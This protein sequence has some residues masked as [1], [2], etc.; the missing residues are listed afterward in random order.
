LAGATVFSGGE[1]LSIFRIRFGILF[2]A[3]VTVMPHADITGL[4]QDQNGKPIQ[5]ALV[6]YI[7]AVD[8]GL[9]ASAYTDVEGRYRIKLPL[10][11]GTGILKKYLYTTTKTGYS[12]GSWESQSLW[13]NLSGRVT[14]PS[15][16]AVFSQTEAQQ[17]PSLTKY[18]SEASHQTFFSLASSFHALVYGKGI[19]PLASRDLALVD[20]DKKDYQVQSIDLWDS[21]RTIL[22]NN[23]SN[24]RFQ[25]EK[26]KTGR[27]AFLGGSITYNSG[28][29]DSVMTYLKKRFPQ[30]TFDFINAGIPSVGSNMHAFRLQQDVFHRGKVDLLFMESL[31]NDITNEVSLSERARAT[32]GIVLQ[33]LKHNPNIDI[34]MMHFVDPAV[35]ADVQAGKPIHQ[36]AEYENVAWPYAVTSIHLAQLVAENY[37]WETFGANVHPGPLGQKIYANA[38]AR[39]FNV[40][41]KDPIPG[42][43]LPILHFLPAKKVDSLCYQFGHFVALDSA[44]LT[45]GWKPVALWKPLAG[46]IRPG[47]T[48]VP[49]LEA[50]AP[51]AKLTFTFTGTAI[52]IV[53]PAGPD[54][55]IL[56]YAIDGKPLGSMQ[57]FTAWSSGLNIP[58]TLN[59]AADLPMKQHTLTLTTSSTKHA[60]STGYACR[61][62]HFAVNGP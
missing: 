18:S 13:F 56:D 55:G 4:V 38:I 14:K 22:R 25:F 28:W 10:S 40:A 12:F 6:R 43:A 31:V 35:Y 15:P 60:N 20:G 49:V 41:W 30:T 1:A 11:A 54:V 5:G 17:R 59:F 24:C 50:T 26:A 37:T 39:L 7:H 3:T 8:P 21:S 27:V 45:S 33:A 46:G 16:H 48:D 53:I 9:E 36:L 52:S 23:L 19:Y 34:V 47:F 32:E 61:I 29:R 57:Q 42:D 2:W 58:W 51:S 62:I 44:Q